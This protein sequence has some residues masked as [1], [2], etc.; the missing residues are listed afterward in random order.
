[1]GKRKVARGNSKS[2]GLEM[3][4]TGPLPGRKRGAMR[5]RA[6]WVR[7]GVKG[8]ERV[9]VGKGPN[10]E[11]SLVFP[12]IIENHS[13]GKPLKNLCRGLIAEKM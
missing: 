12:E 3:V 8:D 5:T 11:G 1:M 4:L 9:E 6:H 7:E 2:Q 13:I 10:H